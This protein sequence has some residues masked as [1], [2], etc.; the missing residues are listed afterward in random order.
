RG[1]VVGER[2]GDHRARSDAA[3][4]IGPVDGGEPK[5]NLRIERRHYRLDRVLEL[6]PGRVG[7]I[8]ADVPIDAEA[9]EHAARAIDDQVDRRD[10]RLE[11]ELCGLADAPSAAAAGRSRGA[12]RA[13]GRG[14]S[15]A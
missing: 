8:G 10:L 4:W 15:S 5:T 3:G 12:G 7:L 11:V 1:D 9:V 6:G 13:R 14:R 2:T